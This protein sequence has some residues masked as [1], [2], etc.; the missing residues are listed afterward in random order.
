MDQVRGGD[1]AEV[2][3]A[4][5]LSPGYGLGPPPASV[6]LMAVTVPTLSIN[7]TTQVAEGVSSTRSGLIRLIR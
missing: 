4:V 5:I 1:G 6:T 2:V 7:I 3:H